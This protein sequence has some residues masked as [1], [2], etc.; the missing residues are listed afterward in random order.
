MDE[1][2]EKI[3]TLIWFNNNLSLDELNKLKELANDILIQREQ[4]CM[5]LKTF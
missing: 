4:P 3:E 2:L 1:E 5:S